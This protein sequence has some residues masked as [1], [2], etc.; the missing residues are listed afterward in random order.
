MFISQVPFNSSHSGNSRPI[1]MTIQT[2]A[3]EQCAV[4]APARRSALA[5][6]LTMLA[7]RPKLKPKLSMPNQLPA[8]HFV[9]CRNLLG[10]VEIVRVIFRLNGRRTDGLNMM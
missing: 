7:M 9:T 4:Q 1:V 5:T 2:H 3:C 8:T 10:W 6:M